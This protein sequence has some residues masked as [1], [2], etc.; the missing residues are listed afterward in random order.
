MN[1]V[2]EFRL[3]TI[4][5]VIMILLGFMFWLQAGAMAKFF[6]FETNPADPWA[7]FVRQIGILALALPLVWA[8]FS[9]QKER[10]PSSRWTMRYSLLS[11]FATA[12]LMFHVLVRS[13]QYGR[14]YTW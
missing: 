9:I 13:M 7:P 1:T 4:G 11:G 8:I 5:G 10:D 14:L 2:S 6:G 3:Q 12:L